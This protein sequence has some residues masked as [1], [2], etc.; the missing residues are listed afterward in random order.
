MK[1]FLSLTAMGLLFT[2]FLTGETARPVQASTYIGCFSSCQAAYN[3]AQNFCQSYPIGYFYDQ[4]SAFGY[5]FRC[6]IDAGPLGW[7]D[8]NP[9][10]NP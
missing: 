4:C 8:I 7:A 10:C 5:Q 2:L 1:R 3:A 6:D 9:N